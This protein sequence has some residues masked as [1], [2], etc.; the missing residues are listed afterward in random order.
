MKIKQKNLQLDIFL[1]S[2]P[3]DCITE[4]NAVIQNYKNLLSQKCKKPVKYSKA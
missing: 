1:Y 3:I 4:S 2:E